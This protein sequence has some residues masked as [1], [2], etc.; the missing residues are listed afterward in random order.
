MARVDFVTANH[1][2]FVR[3]FVLA[4]GYPAWSPDRVYAAPELVDFGGKAWTAAATSQD[5]KPGT[6]G[7]KW[8]AT[9]RPALDLDGSVL[10]YAIR[11][12][13]CDATALV[14]IRSDEVGPDTSNIV[15]TDAAAGAY[16]LTLRLH[17]SPTLRN[18]MA[19]GEYVHALVRIRPDGL[20]E[21]LWQGTVTHS[22]GP[23]R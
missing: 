4:V 11:R 21:E 8:T 17:S 19:A 12:R 15:V 6:D 1:A 13:A 10:V 23:A 9:A 2:D 5:V 18:A 3:G 16:T 14:M 20:R 22:C 7:T